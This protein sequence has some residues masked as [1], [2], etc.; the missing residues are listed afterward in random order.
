MLTCPNFISLF[1]LILWYF[2][3]TVPVTSVIL[4]STPNSVIVEQQIN[5]TCTTSY[6]SPPA[7]ITWIKPSVDI[8]SQAS[9][10]TEENQGLHRTISSLLITVKKEDNRKQ[11]YCIA[12]N[13]PNMTVTSNVKALDVLCK[14]IKRTEGKH[15]NAYF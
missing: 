4:T 12:S 14:C 6:S 7:N 10:R 8:S 2:S 3:N 9:Y 5:I 13:T 15:K 1:Q 11:V